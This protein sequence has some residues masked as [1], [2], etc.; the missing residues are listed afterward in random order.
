MFILISFNKADDEYLSKISGVCNF[1]PFRVLYLF[2]IIKQ[3]SLIPVGFPPGITSH[4]EDCRPPSTP[5]SDN[6]L[7]GKL[8]L[9]ETPQGC[10]ICIL[11][12][13]GLQPSAVRCTRP[14]AL[15]GVISNAIKNEDTKLQ[16]TWQSAGREPAVD[17]DRRHS[18]SVHL[19]ASP[20]LHD[21]LG[22]ILV[23]PPRL[24]HSIPPAHVETPI[25]STL[26]DIGGIA[27]GLSLT[28][29]VLD[30]GLLVVIRA[31]DYVDRVG[32]FVLVLRQDNVGF[33][34]GFDI[35]LDKVPC[36]GVDATKYNLAILLRQGD[37]C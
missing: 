21:S 11:T 31:E 3:I 19:H 5:S 6:P 16:H 34:A 32:E 26:Q 18:H 15:P 20:P 30:D 25:L 28:R 24:D 1:F 27:C 17:A 7:S 14:P 22:S 37:R 10:H 4:R 2:G 33:L 36:G 35:Y 9:V 29:L 23:P 8:F 13:P 12:L